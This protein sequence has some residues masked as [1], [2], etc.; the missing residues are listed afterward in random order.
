VR[1]EHGSLLVAG[2][3]RRVHRQ[4]PVEN[5]VASTVIGQGHVVVIRELARV[6]DGVTGHDVL[7]A[8]ALVGSMPWM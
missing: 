1:E 5:F 6:G 2:E 3:G 8:T 7:D 4:L